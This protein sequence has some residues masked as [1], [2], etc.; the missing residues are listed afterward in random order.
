MNEGSK[1]ELNR[2]PRSLIEKYNF[3]FIEKSSNVNGSILMDLVIFLSNYQLKDLFG[4]IIFSIDDFCSQMGYT[5]SNLQR[6]L[7]PE[8]QKL[9]FGSEEPQIYEKFTKEGVHFHKIETLFEA[10]LFKCTKEN[11][12]YMT[13]DPKVGTSYKGVQIITSFDISYDYSTQ[14]KTKRLYRVSLSSKLTDFIFNHYN[15]IAIKEYRSLPDRRGFRYFYLFLSKMI[16]LVKFK[17][18]EAKEP[19]FTITVDEI[20]RIFDINEKVN[21]E[22]KRR[23]TAVIKTIQKY[24]NVTKFSFEFVKGVNQSYAYT[25]KFH[26]PNET[27]E[28]FNEQYRAVFTKR[29]YDACGILYVQTI[30]PAVLSSKEAL[31]ILKMLRSNPDDEA[32]MLEWIFSNEDIDRKLSVFNFTF[33]DVYGKLPKEFI[34]DWDGTIIL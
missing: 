8:Q 6:K 33:K 23:V 25:L 14:K 22:R 24:L 12:T 32:E 10:A 27:L 18:I 17:I 26:F 28:Y 4:E 3:D 19:Y 20:A 9:L 30:N 34:P 16:A 15:L 5:R 21:K 11:I 31:E 29:Y 2:I 13:V 1:N 7:T